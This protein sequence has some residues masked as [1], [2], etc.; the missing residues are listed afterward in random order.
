[1]TGDGC[2]Q[3]ITWDVRNDILDTTDATYIP[4]TCS[5]RS[6]TWDYNDNCGSQGTCTSSY[7]GPHD[8]NG[9]NPDYLNATANPP[10]FHLFSVSP[11][12]NAGLPGLTSGN[13]DIGAY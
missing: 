3:P 9:V 11:L 2:T 1:V 5:N 4:S 10:N 7:T 8:M 13:N 6:I 12:I